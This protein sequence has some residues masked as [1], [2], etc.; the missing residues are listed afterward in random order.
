MI[1]LHRLLSTLVLS[2]LLAG[3]QLGG[4]LH[5]LTHFGEALKQ[6]TDHSLAAPSDEP[7]PICTLFAGGANAAAG[8]VDV[9]TLA[10]VVEANP[11]SAPRSIANAVRAFLLLQPRSALAPLALRAAPQALSAQ[12]FT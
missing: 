11:F 12:I 6:T 1:R 9:G 8:D 4:E 3:M 10:V 7:C 2:L 5:A